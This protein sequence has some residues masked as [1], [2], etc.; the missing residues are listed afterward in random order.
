MIC[1]TKT[2]NAIFVPLAGAMTMD[3]LVGKDADAY[4]WISEMFYSGVIY[5][6][7]LV[8]TDCMTKKTY[9]RYFGF[10]V[11]PVYGK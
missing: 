8:F 2:K 7:A 3:G 4:I 11:R 5:G 1:S 9:E 6:Q 10:S